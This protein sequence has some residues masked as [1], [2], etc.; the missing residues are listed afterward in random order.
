M[1]FSI[2]HYTTKNHGWKKIIWQKKREMPTNPS[3]VISN[4]KSIINDKICVINGR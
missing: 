4:Y 1:Y 2:S 3:V